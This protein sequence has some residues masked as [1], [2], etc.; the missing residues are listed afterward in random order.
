L[1][2]LRSET[3]R[4]T[5]GFQYLLSVRFKNQISNVEKSELAAGRKK[6]EEK[7]TKYGGKWKWEE[8]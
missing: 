7:H 8:W 5:E 2:Y 1:D 6:K 3:D 4:A